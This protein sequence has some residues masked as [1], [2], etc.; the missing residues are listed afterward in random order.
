MS[1]QTSPMHEPAATP[2]AREGRALP[3]VRLTAI[4]GEWSRAL[5]FVALGL[6]LLFGGYLRL[7]HNNWDASGGPWLP[8]APRHRAAT[9]TPTSA[10]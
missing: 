5:T 10:S 3:R 6:I 2:M 1:E 7:T 8:E 4:T 9:S